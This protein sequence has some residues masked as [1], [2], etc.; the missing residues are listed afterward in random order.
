MNHR[1]DSPREGPREVPVDLG[2]VPDDEGKVQRFGSASHT[3]FVTICMVAW[4][5]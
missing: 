3:F 1:N 2:R 5:R 4:S